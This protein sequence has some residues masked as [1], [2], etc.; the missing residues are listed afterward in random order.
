MS[1]S[2]GGGS[3]PGHRQNQTAKAAPALYTAGV[4][5]EAFP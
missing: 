1:D 2:D 3:R 4:R 5:G